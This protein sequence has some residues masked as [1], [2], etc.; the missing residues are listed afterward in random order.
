MEF[1]GTQKDFFATEYSGYWSIQD[2]QYY[3][4][5]DVLNA[6]DVGEYEA[7]HNARLF[8]ASKDLLD[9]C[10]K[11]LELSDKRMIEE[12]TEERTVEC[13]NVYDTVKSAINKA[14]GL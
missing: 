4:D 9:A 11:A 10:I 3:G 12:E 1:K 14:I 13:Q 2:G 7:E 6:D 8:A 5:S